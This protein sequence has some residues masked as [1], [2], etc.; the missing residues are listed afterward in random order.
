MVSDLQ[1]SLPY[2][3]D[4]TNGTGNWGACE[5]GACHHAADE[6]YMN[7]H[8]YDKALPYAESMKTMG[9]KLSDDY[10]DIFIN[11]MNDETV[12]AVPSGELAGQ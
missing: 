8:Q 12:W 5:Q 2:L 1:E 10:K 7:D 3:Y 6:A 11:E 9:Y 4:K